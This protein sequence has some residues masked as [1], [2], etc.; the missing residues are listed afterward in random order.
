MTRAFFL[1]VAIGVWALTWGP[2]LLGIGWAGLLTEA[3]TPI[4]GMGDIPDVGTGGPTNSAIGTATGTIADSPL[5]PWFN[6][7]YVSALLFLVLVLVVIRVSKFMMHEQRVATVHLLLLMRFGVLSA[8]ASM[9]VAAL[10]LWIEP[11]YFGGLLVML[12]PGHL[13]WV[14]VIALL[15]AFASMAM[16]FA[17]EV[18]A[19]CRYGT[20]PV[21]ELSWGW[22]EWGLWLLMGSLVPVTCLVQTIRDVPDRAME[23]VGCLLLG[24]VASVGVVLLGAAIIQRVVHPDLMLPGLWPRW[25]CRVPSETMTERW[26]YR[27]GSWIA[28][29]FSRLGKGYAEVD[30]NGQSRLSP[31]HAQ[32]IWAMLFGLMGYAAA[33]LLNRLVGPSVDVFPPVFY[34]LLLIMLSGLVLQGGSFFLDYFRV[35]TLLTLLVLSLGFYFVYDTDHYFRLNPDEEPIA[36]V[37]SQS[38]SSPVPTAPESP[39]SPPPGNPLVEKEPSKANPGKMGKSSDVQSA[40]AQ[41]SDRKRTPPMVG[42]GRESALP[43]KRVLI[44]VAAAGG[45]VQA[46]AWTAQVLTKLEERFGENFSDNLGVVSAVSG[47]SLGTMVYLDSWEELQAATDATQRQEL[48]QQIREHSRASSLAATGQGLAYPDFWRSVFPPLVHRDDDRGTRIEAAWK[49]RMRHPERSLNDWGEKMAKGE[50]PIVVFNSTIVET[51]QR[52]LLCPLP[53]TSKTPCTGQAT[54]RQLTEMYPNS[55]MRV[56]T[57]VRLS[58]TFPYVMPMCKPADAPS[59]ETAFHFCDGGYADNEGIMSIL[60]WLDEYQG[61]NQT[62]VILRILPFQASPLSEA[63]S[64]NGWFYSSLGP[65]S[66][67][68]SVRNTSQ[69]ERNDRMVRLF[70]DSKKCAEKNLKVVDVVFE[71]TG[72]N[73]APISWQLTEGQKRNIDNAWQ[74]LEENASRKQGPIAKLEEILQMP[75]QPQP[76]TGG[77]PTPRMR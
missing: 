1:I 50:M 46:S 11:A 10:G 33:G 17:L 4:T 51:G 48:W 32:L 63:S 76:R 35:P 44:C 25:I 22:K 28:V 7:R 75:P 41:R 16:G 38:E 6:S 72:Q 47:G 26:F 57:A 43:K 24:G 3:A 37:D 45:G 18:N 14:T 59:P 39:A 23:L 56:S 65:I 42:A 77:I 15:S 60:E 71:F 74:V 69:V 67:I 62:I 8:M 49:S 55:R 27:L 34:L 12:S 2:I 68:A 73:L 13:V 9:G 21:Q 54:F 70:R 40:M 30:E 36:A 5:N 19:H 29:G 66:A 61:E 52:M 53:T 20:C 31:G 58:A 64:H